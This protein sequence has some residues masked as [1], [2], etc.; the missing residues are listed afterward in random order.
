MSLGHRGAYPVLAEPSPAG[1]GVGGENVKKKG[2]SFREQPFE[3][4][5]SWSDSQKPS[6]QEP[7]PRGGVGST[8]QAGHS[9]NQLCAF[10]GWEHAEALLRSTC[11]FRRHWCPSCWAGLLGWSQDTGFYSPTPLKNSCDVG[12]ITSPLW[13][14]VFPSVGWLG[15]NSLASQRDSM[16]QW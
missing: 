2:H 11:S 15:G 14:L 8:D 13:A 1:G 5:G 7:V 6:L 12:P 4:G 3:M 9:E 16:A 10:W